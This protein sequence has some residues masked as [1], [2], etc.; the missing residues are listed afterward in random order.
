MRV[1]FT[2]AG[3]KSGITNS[4]GETVASFC[5]NPYTLSDVFC[6]LASGYM[7]NNKVVL[8]YG[9]SYVAI[10]YMI[11]CYNI[12]IY[13]YIFDIEHINIL[14]RMACHIGLTV[15]KMKL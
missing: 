13:I 4:F 7:D 5:E 6:Y 3:P 2:M 10:L 9:M 1:L 14:Q 12:D 11:I 15:S 8:A